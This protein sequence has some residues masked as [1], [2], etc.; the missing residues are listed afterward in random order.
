MCSQVTVRL[1]RNYQNCFFAQYNYV[2]LLW[3]PHVLPSEQPIWLWLYY[4]RNTRC[5]SYLWFIRE[6]RTNYIRWKHF[7]FSI[8]TFSLFWC[9]RNKMTFCLH[10]FTQEKLIKSF[11]NVSIQMSNSLWTVGFI[12]LSFLLYQAV[13]PK[14]YSIFT[15]FFFLLIQ[16]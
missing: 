2:S 15:T 16:V 4:I 8:F 13:L 10:I 14:D 12:Q 5:K 9:Y 6:R 1:N 7:P 3:N 11:R